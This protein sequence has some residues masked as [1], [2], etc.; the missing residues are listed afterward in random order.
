MC[1]GGGVVSGWDDAHQLHSR[2]VFGAGNG[3]MMSFD[4]DDA[5]WQVLLCWELTIMA[6][7]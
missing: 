2:S 5:G 1:E 4:N 6:V 3:E 7:V